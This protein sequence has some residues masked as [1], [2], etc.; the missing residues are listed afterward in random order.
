[1]KTFRLRLIFL[2]LGLS[3][4]TVRAQ[5]SR[6]VYNRYTWYEGIA[7]AR[8]EGK[9]F[10]MYISQK[11]CEYCKEFDHAAMQ[12]TALVRFLNEKFVL[13]RHQ[14]SSAYG[15]AFALDFHLSTTPALLVQNPQ[16]EKDPLILYGVRDTAT[17][18]QALS[19]YL[20]AGE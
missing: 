19:A 8:D 17:L 20:A 4:L 5:K 1:M 9:F 14:V 2:F 13:A 3:F 11:G 16:S 15:R 7:K 6:P 10:L 18:R 12:D